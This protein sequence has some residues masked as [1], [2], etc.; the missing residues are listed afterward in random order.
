LK[1]PLQLKFYNKKLQLKFYNKNFN[2][3][4]PLPRSKHFILT[5]IFT[6]KTQQ[7]E[8]M[9]RSMKAKKKQRIERDDDKDKDDIISSLLDSLLT[10]ILSYLPIRDCCNKRFVQQVEASLGSYLC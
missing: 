4:K 10:G 5:K 8:A 7:I 3:Y 2:K 9:V 1:I 6:K